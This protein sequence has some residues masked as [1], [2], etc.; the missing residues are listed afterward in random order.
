MFHDCIDI[1]DRSVTNDFDIIQIYLYTPILEISLNQFVLIII[2]INFFA[3]TSSSKFPSRKIFKY[4]TIN[5]RNNKLLYKKN[6]N[7]SFIKKFLS[8]IRQ[9][10][11]TSIH[12]EE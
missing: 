12:K 10:E 2:S 8:I 6:K 9:K 11:I 5:E 4:K 3:P 7:T 1:V